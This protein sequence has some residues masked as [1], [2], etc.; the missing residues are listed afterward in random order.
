MNAVLDAE[1]LLRP[2]AQEAVME[3]LGASRRGTGRPGTAGGEKGAGKK[4]AA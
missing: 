1:T 4:Q 2:G 3:K